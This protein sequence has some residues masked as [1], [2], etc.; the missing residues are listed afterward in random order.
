MRKFL[1]ALMIVIITMSILWIVAG[2]QISSFVDQFKMAEVESIAIHS[3]SYAGT[4]NGGA[5]LLD[6]HRLTLNPIDPHVGSTRDNELALAYAGKVFA[7]GSLH[8]SEQLAADLPKGDTASFA[9]RRSFLAW[10][11]LNQPGAPQFCRNI[12]YQLV[13]TKQNGAKLEML[14][15]VDSGRSLTLIR[16]D[17]SNGGY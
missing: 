10:P 15:S 2:R 7:F 12:Y 5:L 16:I 3:I 6:D 8:S 17:I 1:I 11:N 9:T 4:G 13:W 14:W